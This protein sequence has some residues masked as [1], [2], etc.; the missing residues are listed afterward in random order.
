MRKSNSLLFWPI[1]A[2][3]ILLACKFANGQDVTPYTAIMEITIPGGQGYG[4]GT[5]VAKQGD[6]GLILTAS[7]V[8][9]QPGDSVGLNWLSV[10][11][12]KTTGVTVKTMGG[13]TYATDMALIV[14]KVPAGIQP[15]KVVKFNPAN[16]PF[17]AAGYRDRLLRVGGPYAVV[18]KT[19]ADSLAIDSPLVH[20]QS[21]G[22]L[23]DHYGNLT[24]VI[25]ASDCKTWAICS[26]GAYLERLL[27]EY[28]QIR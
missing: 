9:L 4:T 22:A 17:V 7:H 23:F 5:V 24:G 14:G 16:G 13:D 10:A 20:G 26:D 19:Q 3:V 12:Q 2:I 28:M 6:T 25:I 27:S 15:V 21:G 18:K 8:A 1:M 11:G